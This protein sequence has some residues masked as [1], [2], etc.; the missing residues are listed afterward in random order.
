MTTRSVPEHLDELIKIPPKRICGTK[1]SPEFAAAEKHFYENIRQNIIKEHWGRAISVA[2]NG[3][4]VLADTLAELFQKRALEF[5]ADA[6]TFN[7]I[8]GNDIPS[9][10]EL[11]RMHS[12]A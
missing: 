11:A 6:V 8:L 7:I 3:M 9:A 4:Y 5:G 10:N 1:L 2:P 12:H